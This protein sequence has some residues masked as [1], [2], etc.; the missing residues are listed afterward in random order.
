MTTYPTLFNKN[1][2]IK[3]LKKIN[4]NDQTIKKFKKLPEVIIKDDAEYKLNTI[5]TYN[6]GG[7]T[8]YSFELNYYSNDLIEFLF[9]YKIFDYF[10]ESINY[11]ICELDKYG[12]AKKEDLM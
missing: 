6:S 1:E 3:F 2:F 7:G 9:N 5:L 12:Y 8:S 11:L 4:V 10:E